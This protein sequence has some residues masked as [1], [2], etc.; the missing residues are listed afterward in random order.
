MNRT[1]TLWILIAAIAVCSSLQLALVLH[2][3]SAP[4]AS[5]QGQY[6]NQKTKLY[7][8]P[9]LHFSL[10][11]PEEYSIIETQDD[12]VTFK[13]A[14]EEPWGFSVQT[15]AVPYPTT[16]SW[17]AAQAKGSSSSPGY[18]TAL[19][20]NAGGSQNGMALVSEYVVVDQDGKKPIYGK[21]LQAVHVEDGMRYTISYR[22]DLLPAE[23]PSVDSDMM[24]I[25]TS[26]QVLPGLVAFPV[27]TFDASQPIPGSR[28]EI[29]YPSRGFYRL[30]SAVTSGA[31]GHARILTALPYDERYGSEYVTLD[32]SARP[33]SKGESIKTVLSGFD[34]KSIDGQYSR[35]GSYRTIHGHQFFI[36]KMTEDVTVWNAYTI[37]NG[38]LIN[39]SLAYKE[40]ESEESKAAAIKNN[41]LF[42]DILDAMKFDQ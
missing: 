8:N 19:W 31:D 34:P 23:I 38:S 42:L 26:F 22:N 3:R 41:Q 1:I 11:Y 12:A 40:K 4:S 5:S 33:L 27:D 30:G 16:K 13:T 17:L 37:S 10:E 9:Q 21:K 28:V 29:S 36:Y 18:E 14:E 35:T 15:E 6:Q 2:Q 24:R 32:A 25:F 20:L 39:I 7:T